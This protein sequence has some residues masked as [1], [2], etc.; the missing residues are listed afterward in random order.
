M[1]IVEFV[2]LRPKMYSYLYQ[3]TPAPTSKV[4]EKHRVKGIT[5]SASRALRHYDYKEQLDTPHENY[6]TNRRLGS[7]LHK[8]YAIS[9]EKRG[10]CSFDD[11]RFLLDDGIH[12]LA[13]GHYSI[14]IQVHREDINKSGGE[15]VMSN[16]EAP[17]KGLI[18]SRRTE[19]LALMGGKDYE[20]NETSQKAVVSGVKAQLEFRDGKEIIVTAVLANEEAAIDQN[21]ASLVNTS[22]NVDD[23]EQTQNTSRK[24]VKK[25]KHLKTS[26]RSRKQSVA[27]NANSKK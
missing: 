12:S 25:Q 14:A 21:E 7:K 2:G 26:K 6:L 11:K 19:V 1:P 22:T 20:W 18:L 16:K 3:N 10:L 9:C 27:S 24:R 15:Q 17:D 23:T 4:M 8:I 5:S 13:Y